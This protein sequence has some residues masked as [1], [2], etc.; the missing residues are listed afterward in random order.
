MLHLMK[1]S[2]RVVCNDQKL[3][4][5]QARIEKLWA[6]DPEILNAPATQREIL[7]RAKESK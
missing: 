5:K 3:R 6:E 7:D 1:G 2:L 4:L